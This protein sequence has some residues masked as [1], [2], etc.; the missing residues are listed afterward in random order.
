GVWRKTR[1]GLRDSCHVWG[2]CGVGQ[3]FAIM[4]ACC[5]GLCV[6]HCQCVGQFDEGV[7]HSAVCIVCVCVCVHHCECVGWLVTVFKVQTLVQISELRERL[8][9]THVNSSHT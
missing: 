6:C 1:G 4:S 5:A 8:R 3:S 2:F 7:A 9:S